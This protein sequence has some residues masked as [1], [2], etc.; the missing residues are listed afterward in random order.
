MMSRD[1][2]VCFS[3]EHVTTGQIKVRRVCD[4]ILQEGSTY[5]S[6]RATGTQYYSEH[7]LFLHLNSNND[8]AL[9]SCSHVTVG[10]FLHGEMDGG[11]EGQVWKQSPRNL[12][13][14]LSQIQSASDGCTAQEKANG[15]SLQEVPKFFPFLSR[16]ILETCS[17]PVWRHPKSFFVPCHCLKVFK[18]VWRMLPSLLFDH[19]FSS[20][21]S[22]SFSS[23]LTIDYCVSSFPFSLI[24]RSLT[25]GVLHHRVK[26]SISFIL[27]TFSFLKQQ[28]QLLMYFG[29]Y[30]NK[31]LLELRYSYGSQ[32]SMVRKGMERAADSSF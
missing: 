22:P 1:Q 4:F 10:M 29:G 32:Q 15:A 5:P 18:L 23:F 12:S 3:Q 21:T 20:L 26:D 8:L 19:L 24:I 28:S 11:T 6:D 2:D 30:S 14:Q 9:P 31:T 17:F 16:M 13:I 25:E 7:F 27:A